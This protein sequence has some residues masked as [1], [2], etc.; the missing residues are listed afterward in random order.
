MIRKNL[1]LFI[2][3]M[4]VGIMVILTIGLIIWSFC[5]G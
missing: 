3:M 4:I 1:D 2:P 5:G